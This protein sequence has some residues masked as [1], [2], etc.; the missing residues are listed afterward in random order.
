MRLGVLVGADSGADAPGLEPAA[1]EPVVEFERWAGEVGLSLPGE[2]R[3]L[4]DWCGG[5]DR[6]VSVFG[7]RWWF[8]FHGVAEAMQAVTDSRFESIF[9]KPANLVPI[10]YGQLTAYAEITPGSDSCRVWSA[11]PEGDTVS[12]ISP[13]LAAFVAALV[14]LAS[15]FVPIDPLNDVEPMW[16]WE[17]PGPSIPY[18]SEYFDERGP[19]TSYPYEA[20]ARV[21]FQG[22][23]DH[24]TPPPGIS[25]PPTV[26]EEPHSSPL[27]ENLRRLGHAIGLA[28]AAPA[29]SA[30]VKRFEQ[31]IYP[32]V[33]AAE[34][35]VLWD[36]CGGIDRPLIVP[37]SRGS[38]SLCGFDQARSLEADIDAEG[39]P[40]LVPAMNLVAI[41][42]GASTVFAEVLSQSEE[43]RVWSRLPGTQ[44]VELICPSIADFVRV[45]N[46]IG[47]ESDGGNPT[48]AFNARSVMAE[49]YP[50]LFSGRQART[51]HSLYDDLV[52]GSDWPHNWGA[53]L[54]R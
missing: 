20:D 47:N 19:K 51:S 49:F 45:L 38:I 31:Q 46:E 39:A 48:A 3:Q 16:S 17:M 53:R 36:W 8:E 11:H 7:Q 40:R 23:P 21:G 35:R 54:P 32:L 27:W 41:A 25:A 2:L 12:L 10:G 30:S 28:E 13:S 52:L 44:R 4:W 15:N 18:Y 22:W 42:Y 43:C 37:T 26:P 9:V 5:V 14:D 1:A 34:L 29:S 24:W 6:P 33:V 50:E